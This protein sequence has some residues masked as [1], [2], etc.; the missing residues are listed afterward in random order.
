MEEKLNIANILKDK[1]KGTKLYADAFELGWEKIGNK[2]YCP[3][4][5]KFNNALNPEK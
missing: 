4:C 1:P 3:N 5:C 2:H